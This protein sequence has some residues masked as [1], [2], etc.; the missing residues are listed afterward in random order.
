MCWKGK[1]PERFMEALKDRFSQIG[2]AW[3]LRVHWLCSKEMR[4]HNLTYVA[5][6]STCPFIA[7]FRGWSA[8][9]TVRGV[10][11]HDSVLHFCKG[12]IC[13]WDYEE[14]IKQETLC[15]LQILSSQK[16]EM[17][18]GE[19]S[20]FKALGEKCCL[21]YAW[22]F[23]C[24]RSSRSWDNKSTAECVHNKPLIKQRLSCV[25]FKISNCS[26]RHTTCCE[27]TSISVL[28]FSSDPVALLSV[29]RIRNFSNGHRLIISSVPQLRMSN[30]CSASDSTFHHHLTSLCR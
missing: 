9:S 20:R 13:G 10:T 28:F 24:W 15:F 1:P 19:A 4:K 17:S 26:F 7:T 30:K 6:G 3:P 27:R 11:R 2:S 8:I 25:S 21:F 16:E 22:W 18:C 12:R 14:E 5:R 29:P 23:G